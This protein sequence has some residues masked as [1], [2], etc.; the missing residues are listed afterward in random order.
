MKRIYAVL[1][2]IA[3]VAF[4]SCKK[5]NGPEIIE[6]NSFNNLVVPTGFTWKM[7]REVQFNITLTDTRFNGMASVISIYNADP[8]TGGVL[9]SRGVAYANTPFKNKI[10][11]ADVI[12]EVYV[13]KTAPDNSQYAIKV[14][15]T[16]ALVNVAMGENSGVV[17]SK[18]S[19]PA[20][21]STGKAT[22]STEPTSWPSCSTTI[23]TSTNNV[24][25]NSGQVLCI[26]GSNITVGFAS[27]N[28]TIL[29][30]GTNVTLS[31][32]TMSSSTA[33]LLIKST[34]SVIVGSSL[35]V[36][37]G[38]TFNNYGTITTGAFSVSG[39]FI[40]EG[41]INSSGTL[42]LSSG[43]ATNSGTIN[44]TTLTTGTTFT[45][46]GTINLSAGNYDVNSG[47]AITNTSTGVIN[48]NAG[49]MVVGGTSFVNSGK[50]IISGNLEVNAPFTNS[51]YLWTKT[52][53]LQS[54][55]SAMINQNGALIR[56]DGT[57]YIN[58]AG[59]T[60][61]GAS[62]LHTATLVMD[63]VTITGAT[64]SSTSFVKVT[65][66]TTVQNSPKF[67][68]TVQVCNPVQLTASIFIN[69]AGQSCTT[70]IP[71]TTCNPVGN[72]T[73]VDTDG[74]GVADGSDAAPTDPTIAIST[75]GKSGT[76]AFEDK[77]PLKGD[78]DM[79]DVVISYNYT[80]WASAQSV[81]RKITAVYTLRAT[82]GEFLNGFGVEFPVLRSA[83]G[84]LT[85]GTLEVGRTNAVVILFNSMR[86]EQ[87]TWNTRSTE[88]ASA[89]KTYNVEFTLP[90]NTVVLNSFPQTEYN[91]F[92]WNGTNGY[93]RAYEI[94]LPGH[95]PTAPT[96]A[97]T[98]TLFGTGN[99]NTS[100]ANSRYYVTSTGLPWA[101]DIPTTTFSYPK[102]GIDIVN[103]YLRLDDWVSST[104]T[105][106]AYADWY[107]NTGTGYRNTANIY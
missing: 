4:G 16:S 26:N 13:V 14:P 75:P 12:T 69:G 49:K 28:G 31:N 48:V 65:S 88:P 60:M 79:N 52:N 7:S 38:A 34:A 44:S 70:T 67:S 102:E 19:N 59:I 11:L 53:Y 66:A 100:A 43:T 17:S 76:L 20:I 92:I 77:W 62:M 94:H 82:G 58:Q 91:P 97:G 96:L 80:L 22:V 73:V 24:S 57:S 55:G 54:S 99:D 39:P 9:L 21:S 81:V 61:S 30:S 10:D 42:T 36:N 90:S 71:V 50:I 32:V 68:G 40:N 51:C 15:V 105:P 103:T 63:N 98:S 78:Y 8:G 41:T 5:N 89:V 93:G 56:V 46:S 6:E 104:T 1:L 47:S 106:K 84:T 85:G 86:D 33:K 37:N 87:A 64:S 18:N 107:S 3:V 25:V 74:D 29:V 95:T 35:Q 27:V 45:N 72:V 23:T 83:V 2:V 101:I